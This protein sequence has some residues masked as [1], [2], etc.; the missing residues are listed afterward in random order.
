MQVAFP[1]VI[2]IY[3][4]LGLKSSLL[5]GR[6]SPAVPDAWSVFLM[7]REIDP[8][9][10]HVGFLIAERCPDTDSNRIVWRSNAMT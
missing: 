10:W 8:Y 6:E 5:L 3:A 1:L 9:L 7:S 4:L 2:V